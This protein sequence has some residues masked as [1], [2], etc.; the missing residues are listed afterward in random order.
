MFVFFYIL[1]K[2]KIYHEYLSK[3]AL[4]STLSIVLLGAWRIGVC[5]KGFEEQRRTSVFGS[6]R[7]IQLDTGEE[8]RVLTQ[9]IKTWQPLN[10]H[11][12]SN[13]EFLID[14]RGC[15]WLVSDRSR[16]YFKIIHIYNL[17]LSV[18]VFFCIRRYLSCILSTA[19]MLKLRQSCLEVHKSIC[20]SVTKFR[21]DGL[22]DLQ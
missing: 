21:C 8:C 3:L 19:N 16:T 5:T 7:W 11:I 22:P 13:T 6:F 4:I 9:S 14:A 2:G 1:L 20:C 10:Q 12:V 17:L 15:E 18:L